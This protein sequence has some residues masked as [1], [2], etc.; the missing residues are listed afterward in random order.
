MGKVLEKLLTNE[1]ELLSGGCQASQDV[2]LQNLGCLLHQ[3]HLQ[4]QRKMQP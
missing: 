2:R 4:T 3:H 1:N